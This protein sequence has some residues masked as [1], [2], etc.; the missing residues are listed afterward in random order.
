L[1]SSRWSPRRCSLPY[2]FDINPN[3][4]EELE[5]SEPVGCYESIG[6]ARSK[7]GHTFLSCKKLL[8][9]EVKKIA[10]ERDRIHLGQRSSRRLSKDYDTL[11]VGAEMQGQVDYGFPWDPNKYESGDGRIDFFFPDGTS[12]DWKAAHRCYNLL[13]EAD[14]K[15]ADILIIGLWHEDDV[16]CRVEWMGWEWGRELEKVDPKV[17]NEEQ[18]IWDHYRAVDNL[19]PMSEFPAKPILP[20]GRL[21]GLR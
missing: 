8:K 1:S 19:R 15:H 11:G 3:D 18:P 2:H 6:R 4:V 14:Q 20:C 5:P 9:D 7:P 12:G 10:R 17:F 21:P 16:F 13:M